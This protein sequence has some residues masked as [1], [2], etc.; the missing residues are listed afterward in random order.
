MFN[1]KILAAMALACAQAVNISSQTSLSATVNE[2]ALAHLLDKYD[3][4]AWEK[5]FDDCSHVPE[6][7]ERINCFLEI[8]V[9]SEEGDMKSDHGMLAQ[10]STQ[11]AWFANNTW[12]LRPNFGARFGARL[13][14]QRLQTLRESDE[15]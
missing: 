1:T 4:K 3:E 15:F 5:A 9:L 7:W 14:E 2:G 12:N 10:T 13:R 8:L 11:W 6:E